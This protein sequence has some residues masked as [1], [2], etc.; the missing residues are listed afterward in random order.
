[1]SRSTYTVDGM[2]CDHCV[3]AVSSEIATLPGVTGVAVDLASGSVTVTS[4]APLADA[5]VAAAADE[6]GY[7][8][9]PRGA[10]TP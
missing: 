2:T 3:T 10:E 1:M 7:K 9:A 5:D 4:D 6:A 8:L